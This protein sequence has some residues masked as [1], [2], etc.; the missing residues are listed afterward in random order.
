MSR[1]AF[2]AVDGGVIDNEPLE[3][4]RRFLSG[5]PKKRNER[6]GKLADKAVLL[7]DPFPNL[8]R[9]SDHRPDRMLSGVALDFLLR[10]A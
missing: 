1:Y 10:A 4:A 9:M 8:V 2:L 5:G 7:I 6:A 3:L